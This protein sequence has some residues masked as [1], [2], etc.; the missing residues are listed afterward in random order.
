M[1][2]TPQALSVTIAFLMLRDVSVVCPRCGKPLSARQGRRGSLAFYHC[3]RHGR[4][5][6]DEDGRLREER[7]SS[8][9]PT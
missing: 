5:W 4:F 2:Q 7:R 6:I 8:D 3:L 1:E 9:R